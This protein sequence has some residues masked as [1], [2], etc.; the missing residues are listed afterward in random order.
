MTCLWDV[1][2]RYGAR[3]GD[4]KPLRIRGQPAP[5]LR[6]LPRQRRRSQYALTDKVHLCWRLRGGAEFL[7]SHS[8]KTR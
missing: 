7:P 2:G 5:S 1:V 8:V 4:V 3:C 6:L